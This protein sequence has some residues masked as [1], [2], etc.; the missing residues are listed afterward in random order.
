MSITGKS[1]DESAFETA[2]LDIIWSFQGTETR[3]DP[4]L[5]QTV[6]LMDTAGNIYAQTGNSNFG[7]YGSV[8][9]SSLDVIRDRTEEITG[10]ELTA[11]FSN[12]IWQSYNQHYPKPAEINKPVADWR[13]GKDKKP[14]V[15]Y[16]ISPT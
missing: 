10:R 15:D 14:A 4:V 16:T 12:A 13:K 7:A 11:N 9:Q 1:P 8:V 2:A 3:E 5:R 6:K